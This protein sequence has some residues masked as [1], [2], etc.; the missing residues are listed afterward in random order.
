MKVDKSKARTPCEE[1]YFWYN[2]LNQFE[3]KFP[4][5]LHPNVVKQNRLRHDKAWKKLKE[6]VDSEEFK[7]DNCF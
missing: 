4:E 2:Q 6:I 5:D 7:E 1:Y 3:D